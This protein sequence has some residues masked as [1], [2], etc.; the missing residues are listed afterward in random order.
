MVQLGAGKIQSL[1]KHLKAFAMLAPKTSEALKAFF[2][3]MQR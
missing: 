3:A 1:K 2:F